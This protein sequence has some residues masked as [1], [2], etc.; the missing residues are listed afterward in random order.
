M[1]QTWVVLLVVAA[2][3]VYVIRTYV[4]AARCEVSTCSGCSGG[5]GHLSEDIKE[6]GTQ[7]P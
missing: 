5:C 4:R 1:W 2:V 7:S 3:L 6:E